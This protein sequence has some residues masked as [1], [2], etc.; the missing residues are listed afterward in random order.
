MA[1]GL[2]KEYDRLS[3]NE[4]SELLERFRNHP[5]TVHF[6]RNTDTPYFFCRTVKQQSVF[7]S[8]TGIS[9]NLMRFSAGF[10]LLA[11]SGYGLDV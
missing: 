4:F 1:K 5:Q 3:K 9:G 8:F 11:G 2:E 10:R 6:F 7:S